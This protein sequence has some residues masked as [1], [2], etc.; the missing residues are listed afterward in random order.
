MQEVDDFLKNAKFILK[1]YDKE[2]EVRKDGKSE[3][4]ILGDNDEIISKT[5]DMFLITSNML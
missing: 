3:F 5:D 4:Y 1:P 2:G